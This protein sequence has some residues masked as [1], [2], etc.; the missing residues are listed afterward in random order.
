MSD[1]AFQTAKDALDKAIRDFYTAVEPEA[2]VHAWVVV[3]H[4]STSELEQSGQSVVGSLV[5][6]GQYFPLTRGLLEV[7]LDAERMT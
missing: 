4:R 7:A 1:E 5:P 6:T 3:A 2:Y